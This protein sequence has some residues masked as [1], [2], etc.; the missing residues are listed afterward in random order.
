MLVNENCLG[1]G[2]ES[3]HLP[4]HPVTLTGKE[5]AGLSEEIHLMLGSPK[6]I[7]IRHW[8]VN[9]KLSSFKD[10]VIMGDARK[11]LDHI[12]GKDEKKTAAATDGS[13]PQ[14]ADND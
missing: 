7:K 2:R 14:L 9:G 6:S 5:V 11:F 8:Q 10:D 1:I 12:R 4:H 13:N 3:I